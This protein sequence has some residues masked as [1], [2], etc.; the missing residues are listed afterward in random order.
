MIPQ[1]EAATFLFAAAVGAATAQ[2]LIR[3][4]L[5]H[6]PKS[7]MRTNFRG[8]VVPA[9]LGGP[10]VMSA[11][12]ALLCV[13][14]LAGLG[15]KAAGDEAMAFAASVLLG[16]LGAAGAWDDR[17]GNERPRGFGGHLTALGGGAITGGVVKALV[18]AGAGAAA[19]WLVGG[20]LSDAIQIAL[21]V[22]LS[23]NLI[24]LFD[25][26]PGRAAKVSLVGA[27]PLVVFGE[28]SWAVMA[29]GLLGALAAATP[30]DLSERAMLGDAGANPVGAI[31]GLGLGTTFDTP[32]RLVCIAVLL[33]LNLASERWSF[34]RIIEGNRWLRALD[35]AGRAGPPW[36]SS[37]RDESSSK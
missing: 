9:L 18:G 22:A 6:P 15:W 5:V 2:L 4:R 12:L 8:I 17:R 3:F 7:L 19:G 1:D 26:A 34:S 25:R 14:V 11:L 37:T 31:L 24:N 32:G 36:K 20:G 23:A 16:A 13:A 28:A 33:S 35:R 30:F 27:L 21:L 10:I 29:G